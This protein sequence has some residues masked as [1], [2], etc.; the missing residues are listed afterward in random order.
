VGRGLESVLFPVH[1]FYNKLFTVK[2]IKK[3]NMSIHEENKTFHVYIFGW[4][5]PNLVITLA[6]NGV[7]NRM[8]YEVYNDSITRVG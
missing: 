7:N 3:Q 2:E 5:M 4:G 1:R 6:N 8:I